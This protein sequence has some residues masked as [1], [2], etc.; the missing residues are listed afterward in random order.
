MPRFYWDLK[1]LLGVHHTT[2]K[3]G[4]S[5]KGVKAAGFVERLCQWL[6]LSWQDSTALIL[7]AMSYPGELSSK[8]NLI[9]FKA[10]RDWSASFQMHWIHHKSQ[11]KSLNV[12]CW[13]NSGTPCSEKVMLYV[14]SKPS[15]IFFSL[16]HFWGNFPIKTLA[17]PIKFQSQAVS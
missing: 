12:F 11:R 10:S 2:T 15:S 13:M 6:V 7:P 1:S 3:D 9:S 5:I 14:L 4:G 16:Y 8:W 17:I